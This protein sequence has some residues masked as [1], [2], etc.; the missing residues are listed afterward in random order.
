M[1]RSQRHPETVENTREWGLGC[2]E[3]AWE[4][5]I[6]GK[7]GGS[8]GRRLIE[9]MSSRPAGQPSICRLHSSGQ[10]QG[11]AHLGTAAAL[12]CRHWDGW[13]RPCSPMKTGGQ[14][15]PGCSFLFSL[16]SGGSVQSLPCPSPAQLHSNT[17]VFS[18]LRLFWEVSVGSAGCELL[19]PLPA[20]WVRLHPV[21]YKVSELLPHSIVSAFY[22]K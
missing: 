19:L 5:W 11:R 4:A 17:C 7:I 1:G 9:L 3:W 20:F 22:W 8:K 21:L 18:L 16:S 2:N 14:C 13:G 15:R 6:S 12:G 10:C